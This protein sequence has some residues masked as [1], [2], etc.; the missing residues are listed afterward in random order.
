MYG[1]DWD[2]GC[3]VCT[4]HMKAMGGLDSLAERDTTFAIVARAPI[5]KINAYKATT[6]IRFPFYSS[7]RS[8]FNFD[9]DMSS[10]DG[11]EGQG[12]SVF[13][14]MN[15]NVYHTYT[16][17]QRGVEGITNVDAFLDITPYGRQQDFE[18]SPA[19]WP[20]RPTYE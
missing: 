17:Q 6:G 20:Q 13:F 7:Y 9:M 2:A 5:H 14:Q 4:A 1:P 18:D 12:M 10:V 19:G 3:P 11:G 8:S 15:G 16:A